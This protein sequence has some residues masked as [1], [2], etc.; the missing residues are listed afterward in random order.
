LGVD[1]F[2]PRVFFLESGKTIIQVITGEFMTLLLVCPDLLLQ[3]MVVHKPTGMD[4]L[5][6][7][8]PEMGTSDTCGLEAYRYYLSL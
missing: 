1:F 6:R 5:V 3:R 2:Q 8:A 7:F 4:V